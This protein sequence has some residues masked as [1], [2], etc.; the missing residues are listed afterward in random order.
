MIDRVEGVYITCSRRTARLV[1]FF[2]WGGEG[3]TFSVRKFNILF[4]PTGRL[5]GDI[6]RSDVSD[7]IV[8]ETLFAVRISSREKSNLPVRREVRR[9]SVS[10]RQ[11]FF[12]HKYKRHDDCLK[13]YYC[14]SFSNTTLPFP[15]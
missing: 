8:V 7:A 11:S 9:D 15:L 5:I 6:N 10:T 13:N 12:F 4:I 3:D 2:F 1:L 14:K